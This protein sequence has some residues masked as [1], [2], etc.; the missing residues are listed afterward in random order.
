MKNLLLV[1]LVC[2]GLIACGEDV[3]P[4]KALQKGAPNTVTLSNGEVVYKLDGEWSC[5][6]QQSM[7]EGEPKDIIKISQDGNTFVG[8]YINGHVY[9]AAG[10]GAIKGE[11]E[12]N[13]FKSVYL[14][15]VSYF[16]T[17]E[18]KSATGKISENCNKIITNGNVDGA[19]LKLTL[20]R[21]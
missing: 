1:L 3:E 14:G 19:N 21:K 5:V 13:G 7:R 15:T 4:L 10:T 11:L 18:W 12:K 16:G 6:Y 9:K 17:E 2:L 8:I 20:T